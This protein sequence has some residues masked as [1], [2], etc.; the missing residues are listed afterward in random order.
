MQQRSW[1]PH[2][3]VV[4]SFRGLCSAAFGTQEELEPRLGLSF[5]PLFL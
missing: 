3:E 4:L 1:R 2:E 5:P